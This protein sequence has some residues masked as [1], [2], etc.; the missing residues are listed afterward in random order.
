[1]GFDSHIQRF[2]T[3]NDRGINL[4]KMDE[5]QP[6]QHNLSSQLNLNILYGTIVKVMLTSVTVHIATPIL[7]QYFHNITYYLVN[8]N[9]G[10]GYQNLGVC[11]YIFFVE[12]RLINT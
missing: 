5:I 10:P 9:A 11:I 4:R 7:K 2:G 8:K 3:Y 1:M 12:Y 6:L